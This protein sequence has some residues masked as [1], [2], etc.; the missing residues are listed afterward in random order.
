MTTKTDYPKAWIFDEDGDEVE[1]G[2]LGLGEGPTRGYGYAPFIT[3]EVES[4]PR[5]VWMLWEALRNQI[6]RELERR[7]GNEFEP[8]E[9]IQIKRLGKKVSGNNRSYE[10]FKAFFPDAPKPTGRDMLAKYGR[11]V[12]QQDEEKQAP[13]ETDSDGDIPF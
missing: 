3:L 11:E 9:T 12:E 4:E 13:S 7:P 2:Y 1:G 10:D 5:T 6:L 8:G